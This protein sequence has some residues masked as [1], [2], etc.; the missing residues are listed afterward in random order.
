MLSSLITKITTKMIYT[1]LWWNLFEVINTLIL[2]SDVKM[3]ENVKQFKENQ[4]CLLTM[5][6][7]SD[8]VTLKSKKILKDTRFQRL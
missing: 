6:E 7:S 2:L 3:C 5:H 4:K 8:N 1:M